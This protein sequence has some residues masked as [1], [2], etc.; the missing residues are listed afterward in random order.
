MAIRFQRIE[1][2]DAGERR[3]W[4]AGRVWAAH[5]APYLASAL[6]ALD[7]VVV[8]RSEGGDPAIDLRSFPADR[9]WHLYIDLA[10]LAETEVGEL[11]F[12][13]LHQVSHLLRDH[14]PRFPGDEPA[15]GPLGART[16]EQHRWNIAA[17]AEINDDLRTAS[18][19]L[20]DRA[21][22]P[23]HYELA[24][25]W[26][27]EQY[28]D[29][30]AD[31]G[32][33]RVSTRSSSEIGGPPSL[34]CSDDCG[35][36]VDGRDRAWD[37]GKPGLTA[38]ARQLVARDTARRILE[39]TREC[40]DTPA[41]W[42]RWAEEV[43]EPS[44]NWRRQLAAQVRRG[45]AAVSGQ[46]DFTYRRPSRRASATPDVVLPSLR[47]PLPQVALVV[48][49]SGSMSD[50]MLGQAL[51]EVT[52]VLRSLGVARRNLRLIACDAQAHAVQRVYDVRAIR[53]EGG[54]GTD[55]GAGLEAAAE[56]RPRPDLIVV[57]TDGFTPW[58]SAPPH[59]IPVIVG[60]MDPRGSTPPW[61]RTVM[62][63][64]AVAGR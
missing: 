22:H 7:P 1:E 36:G 19:E 57:L 49:T 41:G 33:E 30:L 27:A 59:E 3:R 21:I 61:A 39:H 48:D 32:A 2:R 47:Q 8:D 11:G 63:G 31:A 54:G 40:G 18:L 25:G 60:L 44:T 13:L 34:H 56:L 58:R 20:P 51:A 17:D 52:G 5:E 37:C 24:D 29:A 15:D 64:D 12:W 53:L 62:I 35:S 9:S 38:V 6:L 46:V 42:Q 26:T 14:A 55:M 45:T 4:A 50:A 10:V 23:S 28:W 16:P 43:L